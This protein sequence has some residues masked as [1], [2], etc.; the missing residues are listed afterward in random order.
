M[1][2]C[3]FHLDC[4]HAGLRLAWGQ[5]RVGQPHC[6][7]VHGLF[8]ERQVYLCLV[9]AYLGQAAAMSCT[10]LLAG[11]NSS[12]GIVTWFCRI[13]MEWPQV[14]LKPEASV[15][16]MPFEAFTVSLITPGPVI[17]ATTLAQGRVGITS[18]ANARQVLR[19]LVRNAKGVSNRQ[20]GKRKASS[21]LHG[22]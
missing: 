20:T 6:S 18:H 5:A 1:E 17:P 19:L 22:S 7:L 21:E 3:G 13:M 12:H 14:S 8:D 16:A 15:V 4:G 10:L 11:S 9:L 2:R